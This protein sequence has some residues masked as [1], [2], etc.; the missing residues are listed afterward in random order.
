MAATETLYW[1]GPQSHGLWSPVSVIGQKQR[2]AVWVLGNCHPWFSPMLISNSLRNW[3]PEGRCSQSHTLSWWQSRDQDPVLSPPHHTF[4]LLIP[5]SLNPDIPEWDLS[6]Y[7]HCIT[8]KNCCMKNM[9]KLVMYFLCTHSPTRQN[10]SHSHPQS[11]Q[12]S[13]QGRQPHKPWG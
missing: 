11:S 3:G 7:S 5:L 4:S 1:K 2:L 12:R 9:S 6:C 13:M 8:L 10:L